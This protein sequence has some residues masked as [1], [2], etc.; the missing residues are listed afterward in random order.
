M[1]RKILYLFI[2][3]FALLLAWPQGYFV[4][5]T[6]TDYTLPELKE[7]PTGT[8]SYII[9]LDRSP[10]R[11]NHVAPKIESL[12]YQTI[13]IPAIDGANLSEKE[14]LDSTNFTS[15]KI[16]TGV[17]PKRGTIGCSLSH[18]NSWKRF[19]E[20]DNEFA[21]IF[22]DDVD[23]DPN[24]LK[25][26]IAK[27]Q[28]NKDLWDIV[29]FE[30]SHNGTPLTLR[31]LDGTPHKLSVYLTEISHTG[32]YILNRNAAQKLIQKFFPIKMPVDHYM[33]RAWEFNLKYTGIEPRIMLQNYGESYI[34]STK[35]AHKEQAS[36]DPLDYI[37]HGLYKIQSYTTR[38]FYNLKIYL[39]EKLRFSK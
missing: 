13:R 34:N 12:G 8:I 30:I 33:T 29:T 36:L 9:N 32:A 23:F 20:S 24:T 10:E 5:K 19:L 38:F 39:R 16:F 4:L 25:N 37:H 22:E 17:Y 18:F 7:A 11:Y 27:L 31:I 21:V 35:S 6:N 26:I 28:Q 15:F 3:V 1:I 14:L 2:V